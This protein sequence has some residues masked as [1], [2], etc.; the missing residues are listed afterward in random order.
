MDENEVQQ[1]KEVAFYTETLNAWYTTRFEK[2]KHLLTLSSF[3]IGLLVTLLT[4][5]G[6]SSLIV[7]LMYAL[8][9]ISFLICIVAILMV[10]SRNSV[11]LE[12]IVAGS[13]ENDKWLTVLDKTSVVSFVCGILFTLLIGLFSG[14]DHYQKESVSM[15]DSKVRMVVQNSSNVEKKSI[16]GASAMRPSSSSSSSSASSSN[17]QSGQSSQSNNSN[18]Q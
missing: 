6:V 10:F 16:N 17:Q 8:A 9:V 1:Q 15:S 13:N 11:H 18:S 3:G 4:T 12:A 5:V 2:D 7:A 14:V